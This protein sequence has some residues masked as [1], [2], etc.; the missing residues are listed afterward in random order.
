MESLFLWSIVAAIFIKNRTG[1]PAQWANKYVVPMVALYSLLLI[2]SLAIA[3]AM[4]DT[5]KGGLNYE[6]IDGE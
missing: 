1:E 4:L 5:S 3:G 6:R 2:C